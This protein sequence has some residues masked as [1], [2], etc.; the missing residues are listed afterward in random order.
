MQQMDVRR[1]L[2]VEVELAIK[3]HLWEAQQVEEIAMLRVEEEELQE[4][5]RLWVVVR[6]AELA[7]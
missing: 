1:E 2:E 6:V 3:V 5:V 7:Y 4:E